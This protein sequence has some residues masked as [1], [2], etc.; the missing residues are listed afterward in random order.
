M[1]F[2]IVCKTTE[3]V[4]LLL[5]IFEICSVCCIQLIHEN[6]QFS[7]AFVNKIYHRIKDKEK[8]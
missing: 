6:F 3:T 1:Y 4:Y 5:K 7:C 8:F 2:V